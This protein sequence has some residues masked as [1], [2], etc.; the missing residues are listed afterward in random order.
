MDNNNFW[1]KRNVLVT[2]GNGFIGGALSREL[3]GQRANVTLIVRDWPKLGALE[4]L[5]L[6]GKVNIVKGSVA[7]LEFILRILAEYDIDAVFHLAAQAIVKIA[8]ASP[9]STFESNIKGTWTILEACRQFPQ[10]KRIVVASSDKAYGDQKQLPYTE[11]TPLLGLSPYDASKACAD[12][13]ARSFYHTYKLPLAVTRCANTYGEGDLNISRVIPA[14]IISGLKGESPVINNN[15]ISIRDF[16]YIKD[17]VS[18]YLLLAQALDRKEIQGQP[19]NFGLNKP[20]TMLDLANLILLLVGRSDIKPKVIS[21]CKTSA[22]IDQQSVSFEK[23]KTE[24]GWE[25]KWSLEQGLKETINWY[26]EHLREI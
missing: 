10:V 12:I 16:L 5:G 21:E 2:G 3:V 8:N 15:G 13:L 17:A 7:D 6:E 1:Q 4:F 25:P 23:A 14:V 26:K 20:V 18:A 24:L 19:Y 22:E 9:L 11:D